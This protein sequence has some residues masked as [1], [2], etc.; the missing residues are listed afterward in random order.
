MSQFSS[1]QMRGISKSYGGARALR[2]VDFAASA[3]EVHAIAGENGAGKST[4]MKILSGVYEPDSG[5]ILLNGK[6]VR[7]SSPYVA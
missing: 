6:V 7:I 4:L 5:E 1:L 2:R 3:G